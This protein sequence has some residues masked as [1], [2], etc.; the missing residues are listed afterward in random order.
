MKIQKPF[1]IIGLSIL[2]IALAV[3]ST[4]TIALAQTTNST[5]GQA[6]EIAPPVLFLKADPGQTI[7][8]QISLRNI[9]KGTLVVSSQINDFVANGENGVPKLILEETQTNPNSMK[10]WVNPLAELT[11]SSRQLKNLPVTINVPS[12]ASPGGYYGVVRFT[13]TPP[14]L[15]GTGVSLSASL[16]ALIFLRINGQAK[17]NMSIVEFSANEGGKTGTFFESAPINFVERIKNDGNI[18][19]QPTGQ[20][21]ITDM[22]GKKVAAV[23]INLAQNYILPNSTRKFEETLD[24]STIGDKMLFGHYTADMTLTYGANKQVITKSISFWVIPYR[25][26]AVV[27]ALVVVGVLALWFGIKRYNQFIISKAQQ[28]RHRKK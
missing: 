24:R 2:S 23:N 27:A 20:I 9:S 26:I 17:E 19:E 5:S 22:F 10:T 25:L 16:G 14:D 18:F 7:T 28:S 3:L 11:M 12:D 4:T 13:A 6:L 1:I 15:K 21:S 8:S